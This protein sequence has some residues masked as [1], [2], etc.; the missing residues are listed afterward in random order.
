MP[1]APVP[2]EFPAR[3][4]TLGED[5]LLFFFLPPEAR[6][7]P[8]ALQ[9]RLW[10]LALWLEAQRST[11]GLIEI[12]PGMGNLMVRG[13]HKTLLATLQDLI[14]SHWPTLSGTSTESRCIE[15]PVHYGGAHGPDLEALA[16]RCGLTPEELIALHS[17]RVYH[18]NCLGFQPGFA[19]LGGLDARLHTPRLTTPRVVVP[20]GSVAIGGSQTAIYPAASPG[21]WH[22]IGHTEVR[23]FDP[24]ASPAV[25]LQPGDTVRFVRQ[26]E[27][28]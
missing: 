24:L 25:L 15:I 4:T 23:L 16:A 5:A 2:D 10:A 13:T 28:S 11:L 1:H 6:E 8:L 22:L 17:E 7:V 18:V 19:Y 3:V 9:Q 14:L 26:G 27:T 20:A 12:V 21:G